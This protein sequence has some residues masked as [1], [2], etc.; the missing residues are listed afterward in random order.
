[1]VSKVALRIKKK[2]TYTIDKIFGGKDN[3]HRKEPPYSW[4]GAGAVNSWEKT[5]GRNVS[6]SCAPLYR[7]TQER[8]HNP[9]WLYG[10]WE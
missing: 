1:M 7:L 2:K 5:K 4:C 6:R 9:G 8:R 3:K 10:V